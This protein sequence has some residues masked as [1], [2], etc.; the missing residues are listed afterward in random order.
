MG[1]SI[2]LITPLFPSKDPVYPLAV[3]FA[4]SASSTYKAFDDYCEAEGF[5]LAEWSENVEELIPYDAVFVTI[6]RDAENEDFRNIEISF[7][8]EFEN[9]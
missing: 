1:A 2:G 5:V 8:G 9:L 6:G 4:Y 7:R 3:N